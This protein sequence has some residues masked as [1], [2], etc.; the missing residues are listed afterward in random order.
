MAASAG[1]NGD[2]P[3]SAFLD[4]LVRMKIVDDVVKNNAAI[5]VYGL[6]DLF[7]CAQRTDDDGH[8][9]FHAHLQI[10]FE[11]GVGLVD[12]LVDREGCSRAVRVFR[13]MGTEELGQPFVELGFRARI[14]RRKR[15]DDARL[16]L[17]QHQWRM[18]NDEQRR[19]DHRN[20]E[21]FLEDF[22]QGHA[23]APLTFS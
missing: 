9:V 6:V 2:Q 4:R 18:R 10:V 3:V 7:A 22:R 20:S 8:L 15:P 13:I 11:T 12:D 16:A 5:G 14:E 23:S 1:C 19:A 17:R 21:V